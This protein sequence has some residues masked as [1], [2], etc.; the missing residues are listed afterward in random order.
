MLVS[1]SGQ[2]REE[3]LVDP[4]EVDLAQ[5]P[6]VGIVFQEGDTEKLHRALSLETK[7]MCISPLTEGRIIAAKMIFA[8]ANLSF[9]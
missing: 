1:V 4:K 7:Y 6:V 5:Y 2:R 9:L 3:V 8:A